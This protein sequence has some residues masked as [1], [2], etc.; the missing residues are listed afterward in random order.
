M[1][2]NYF[3]E[4]D[5]ANFELQGGEF[6]GGL[7]VDGSL[8]TSTEINTQNANRVTPGSYYSEIYFDRKATVRIKM[9]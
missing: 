1:K 2:I 7:G 4:I 9:M 3:R 8:W 5:P 6:F